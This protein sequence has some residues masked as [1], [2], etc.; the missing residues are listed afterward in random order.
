MPFQKGHKLSIGNS[1]GGRKG[2]EFEQK[3]MDRMTKV[4]SM[5]LDLLEKGI[6]TKR[7]EEKL[8]RIEKVALKILDKKH[9][10]KLAIKAEIESA[11]L[12]IDI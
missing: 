11:T 3:E 1:G 4:F 12:R 5:Y 10:N 9:P 8:R 7:E 6:L 2:Y